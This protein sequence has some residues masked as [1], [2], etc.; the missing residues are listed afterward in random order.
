MTGSLLADSDSCLVGDFERVQALRHYLL[1]LD[2]AVGRKEVFERRP[3]HDSVA[4]QRRR[5]EDA[6]LRHPRNFR[7]D[8][9]GPITPKFNSHLGGLATDQ[10]PMFDAL[11]AIVNSVADR[12]IRICM[13]GR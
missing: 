1:V 5:Q 11:D 3:D 12:V 4:R 2:L 9:Y 8:F 6:L 7:L 13:R 10:V